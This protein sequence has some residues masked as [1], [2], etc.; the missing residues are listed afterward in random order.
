MMGYYPD[1]VASSYPPEKIDFRRYDWIDFA[2]AL[3]NENFELVWDDPKSSPD[4]L[5]RLVRSA[6]ASGKKVKL[7]VGGATGSRYF[8][9]AVS[10]AENRATFVKNINAVVLEFVVD[11][12]DLDWEYPGQTSGGDES[13]SPDDTANFLTFLQLLR[14]TLPVGSRITAATQTATF[15][16]DHGEPLKDVSEFAKVLDAITVMAYDT[17]GSSSTKPGANAPLNNGC[18]NS[19]QPTENAVGAYQQWTAAGFPAS[20]IALGVPSYGYISKS[21]ATSLEARSRTRSRHFAR[22]DNPQD[23]GNVVVTNEDGTDGGQVQFRA[24]VAQGAL[25][26][27]TSEEAQYVGGGGFERD[28]HHCSS[29]PWLRSNQSGQI[30][31]YDDPQSLTMKAQFAKDVGLLGVCMWDVHGDTD[32]WALTDALRKGLYGA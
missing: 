14:A 6:H 2:F 17:W 10:S 27:S 31:T 30:I 18:H 28:W 29:T 23:P 4:V 15:V 32:D 25:V 13:F 12:V 24:L 19:S 7:S 5:R 21:I 16:D 11:G 26:K 1:W 9:A 22:N 8:S 3:P 20:Q